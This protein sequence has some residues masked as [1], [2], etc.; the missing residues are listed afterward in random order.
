[1]SP[2]LA[3]GSFTTGAT[4]E[5]LTLVP[6][7]QKEQPQLQGQLKKKKKKNHLF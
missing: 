2:A 6:V 4:W 3:G 7:S 5:A 1:M